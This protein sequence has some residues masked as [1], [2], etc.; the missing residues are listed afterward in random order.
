MSTTVTT[1]NTT[2]ESV[3]RPDQPINECGYIPLMTGRLT[4]AGFAT[5]GDIQQADYQ[6]LIQIKGFGAQMVERLVLDLRAEG[7]HLMNAAHLSG[8]EGESLRLRIQQ[9][10]T[11]TYDRSGDSPYSHRGRQGRQVDDGASTAARSSVGSA[12]RT[13]REP[14]RQTPYIEVI[15]KQGYRCKNCDSLTIVED[16]ETPAGIQYG[17]VMWGDPV[18]GFMK[19]PPFYVCVKCSGDVHTIGSLLA[20]LMITK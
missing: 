20:K 16:N 12:L 10:K 15:V 18:H 5:W 17:Q 6:A 19:I 14:S 7:R 11:E 9:D 1:R 8:L 13:R 4:R 2:H 3:H